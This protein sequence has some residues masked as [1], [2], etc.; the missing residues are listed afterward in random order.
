VAINL[1]PNAVFTDGTTMVIEIA[2][3]L[4]DLLDKARKTGRAPF[5]RQ[6]DHDLNAAILRLGEEVSA[7]GKKWKDVRDELKKINPA[8]RFK[9]NDAVR[10]RY[11]RLKAKQ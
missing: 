7:K 9:S 2:A 1:P 5:T 6:A 4:A 3:S 8:W 10:I 11:R